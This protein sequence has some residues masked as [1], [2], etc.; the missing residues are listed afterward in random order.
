[1]NQFAIPLPKGFIRG[2]DAIVGFDGSR[3]PLL[4]PT[5]ASCSAPSNCGSPRPHA[6][7]AWLC[8]P[9]QE[10]NS[11]GPRT[12]ADMVVCR[13]SLPDLPDKTEYA[14]HTELLALAFFLT[15]SLHILTCPSFLSLAVV[16]ECELIDRRQFKTQAEAH[17]TTFVFIIRSWLPTI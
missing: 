7:G 8:F 11:T 9:P 1:M 15:Y 14:A 5:L 10:A 2:H 12:T 17:N 3:L 16:L 13:I 6:G 4:A